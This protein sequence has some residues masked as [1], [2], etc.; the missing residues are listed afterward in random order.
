MK[1]DS[2]DGI[3]ST[4]KD[5]SLISKWAGGI[6][7]HVHN[8]RA[9]SSLI[10]G[11][12]GISNGLVPML[13]VFNNT[14]QYVDQ[15]VLPETKIYTTKG[16]MKMEE[17]VVGETEIYNLKG[18]VEKVENVLEH[19]YNGKVLSIKTMHSLDNLTITPE[20]PVYCLPGQT[21][22]IN[23]SIIK[24]RIEK[25]LVKPDWVDAG[26]LTLNDMLAYPIPNYEN[27][28]S[29]IKEDDC[30]MYGILLG[31]G[32]L[33][34]SSTNGYISLNKNTKSDILE[35]SKNYF[36]SKFVPFREEILDNTTR[37]YWSKNVN[38]PFKYSEIY[39]NKEKICSSRW[40][41]LPLNKSRM[42]L[43]GLIDTDGSKGNELVFDSTSYNLIE[44]VRFLCM[45][46]GVL[47]S[48][49]VRDR[50]GESHVSKYG[51]TITNKKISYTLRIPKTREICNL[52]DIPV[53]EK[54][55]FFKFFKHENILYTR[56]KDITESH[57]EG[58]LYD[59][60]MSKEHNYML[61]QGLVHN[62]GGKRNGSIAIYLE[63]W[64]SDV[65]DFLDLRKNHGNEEERARDLFYAKGADLFMERVKEDGDWTL[66]CPDECPSLSDCYG[67]AFK[68]LYCQ[69][70]SEGRGKKT[71]K[72]QDLWK[73]IIESQIET[74]NHLSSVQRC[75]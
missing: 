34:N 42:I 13:R 10:R 24:N 47:T 7:L 44:A 28:I 46:M 1:E 75:M 62:G 12:N 6:G 67:Q 74:G 3:Y 41:N 5:C 16:P 65:E 49:Y 71:I 11:T 14:A 9:K 17:V 20:H 31:D 66:M 55:E 25:G 53:N 54:G 39:Q 27:D 37:I 72:A 48:G 50:V 21:K 35:F 69:Y 43:K 68:E 23:Y 30:Y 26:E 38:L 33:S 4:L 29:S 57:Y 36:H 59:L 61:H 73:H 60:Q 15:C 58:T 64:H 8:I 56:I 45:K 18:E 51:D 52:L 2:I 22:G 40:L 19:P 63:P 70:E 32:S